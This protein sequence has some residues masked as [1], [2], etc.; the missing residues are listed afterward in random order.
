MDPLTFLDV[1]RNLKDSAV[2]AEMRTAI[3]RSYYAVFNHLRI[4]IERYKPFPKT[5]D[6][7]DHVVHYLANARSADLQSVAQHV[8]DLRTR[9]NDADYDMQMNI[10]PDQ[11]KLAYAKAHKAL[12]KFGTVNSVTLKALIDALPRYHGRED[13]T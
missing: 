3:G 7:H 10:L 1:A 12:E 6:I 9:R 4:E 8:R 2:E 13:R 11:T 5:A